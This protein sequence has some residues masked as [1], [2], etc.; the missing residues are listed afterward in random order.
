MND[1]GHI[2]E[3]SVCLSLHLLQTVATF[4][5]DRSRAPTERPN[6]V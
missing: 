2:E 1:Y 5:A 4:G 6:A 3:L